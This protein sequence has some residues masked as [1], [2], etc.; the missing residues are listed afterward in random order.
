MEMEVEQ[1]MERLLATIRAGREE[2]MA[3]MDAH[4]KKMSASQERTMAKIG[5]M[6]AKLDTSHKIM[7]A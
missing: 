6:N 5:A 7:M 2:M 3:E 1:M 4:H